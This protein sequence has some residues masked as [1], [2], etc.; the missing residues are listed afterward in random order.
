MQDLQHEGRVEKIGVSVYTGDDID[1][2]LERFEPS[3]VQLPISIVD[4]RLLQSAHLAKLKKRGV[5]IHARSVFLQ[6]LLLMNREDRPAYF[7]Q[8]DRELASY[9][10]FLDTNA[11]TPLEA[12]LSFVREVE[13]I[14][15]ALV[16]VTSRAQLE[17]CLTALRAAR[18]AKADFSRVACNNER[19]LNPASWPS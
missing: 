16:G 2:I 4:Q 11:I 7:R 6:G 9:N 17:A 3:L 15:V 14:D 1:R 10:R 18:P 8:F 13:E 12:A 19:L 5:E